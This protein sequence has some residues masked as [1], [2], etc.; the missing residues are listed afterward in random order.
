MIARQGSIK[1]DFF[2]KNM[3]SGGCAH[4]YITDGILILEEP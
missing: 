2:T 1:Y 4:L 3:P